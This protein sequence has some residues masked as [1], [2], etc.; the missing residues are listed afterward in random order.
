MQLDMKTQCERCGCSLFAGGEAYICS[1]ECTFCPKCTSKAEGICPHCGG[2]LV[3]RPRRIKPTTDYPSQSPAFVKQHVGLVWILS[4]GI[5]T[6]VALAAALSIY[7]LYRSTGRPMRF[8][9]VLGLECS[10]I[11]PYAP[12]TPAAFA[13][14]IRLPLRRENWLRPLMVHLAGGFAFSTL[15][16]TMRA[17]TPYAF[18]DMKTYAWYSAIWDYQAHVFKVQWH[19]F[20]DLFFSNVVDDITG[21][22]VPIVLVAHMASY[23]SRLRERERR[24]SQL[25]GQLVKANLQALKGQL[26]PHFLFNTMHSISALMLTDVR[27]ADKMMS[28]LSDLLRMS[29]ESESEQ[30][31][32]LSHEVEF[33]TAYLEIEKVRFGDRLNVVLDIAA[34]TLD[35]QVPHLLLQP[36]VENAVRHGIARLSAGGEI[37][38]VSR[39][40]RDRLQLAIRDNGPGFDDMNEARSKSG[41][42]LRATQERLQTLYGNDHALNLH[43]PPEGGI[44][45]CLQIPFHQMRDGD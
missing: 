43:S 22:Y 21:A 29:L 13:L 39:H 27:A 23:Y 24:A 20:K 31:T 26:Q 9:D 16:I 3:R 7:E 30:I 35:A 37:Q 41:L 19:V 5:W 40:D 4:F 42:G 10:Q 11:L 14:A 45:V 28:R 17:L 25:E 34:D 1:H 8:L 44:E 12:L 6:F 2:E 32:S 36:L 15:H 33:A 18:W 38:L